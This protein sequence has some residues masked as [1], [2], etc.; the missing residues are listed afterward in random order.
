MRL[1]EH[2]GFLAAFVVLAN[3]IGQDFKV[4]RLDNPAGSASQEA[5]YS[6]RFQGVG[7]RCLLEGVV[8]RADADPMLW[9]W[10]SGLPDV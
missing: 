1:L 10:S 9:F 8:R 2:Q 5:G 4:R 6:D 7:A 3:G